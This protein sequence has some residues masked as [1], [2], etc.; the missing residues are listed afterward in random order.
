MSDVKRNLEALKLRTHVLEPPRIEPQ[1]L[2]SETDAY[3]SNVFPR[4]LQMIITDQLLTSIAD[5]QTHRQH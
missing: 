2:V 4:N 5:S 1:Y 3:V